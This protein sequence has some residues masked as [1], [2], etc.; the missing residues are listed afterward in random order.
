[1]Q[2]CSQEE[3]LCDLRKKHVGTEQHPVFH[4]GGLLPADLSTKCR[5]FTP[6]VF[7]P[8]VQWTI[9]LLEVKEVFVVLDMSD[10]VMEKCAGAI[11]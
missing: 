10:T 11:E 1:M 2:P 4:G 9:W 6:L 3:V 8:K 5:V 7:A